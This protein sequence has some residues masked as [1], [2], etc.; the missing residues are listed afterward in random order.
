MELLF[1][2]TESSKQSSL[3]SKWNSLPILF[4]LINDLKQMKNISIFIGARK[5]GY[6]PV[7]L[8]VSNNI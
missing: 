6:I 8:F 1:F 5:N 7:C 4:L 3:Y 2:H